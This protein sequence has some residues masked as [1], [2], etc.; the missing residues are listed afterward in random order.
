[1]GSNIG[2]AQEG[3][4]GH[5]E[6]G[7]S[8]VLQSQ[9]VGLPLP[10]LAAPWLAIVCLT[11]LLIGVGKSVEVLIDFVLTKSRLIDFFRSPPTTLSYPTLP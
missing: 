1:M 8:Q 10:V 11:G 9:V 5:Q 2:W 6:A 3:Y 7:K 4:F